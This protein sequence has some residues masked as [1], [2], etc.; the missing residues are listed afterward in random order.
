MIQLRIFISDGVIES[1]QADKES[2][3][4]ISDLLNLQIINFDSDTGDKDVFRRMICDPQMEEIHEY[5]IDHADSED[6]PFAF[7]YQLLDRLKTDCLYFL[8]YGNRN[9][10]YLWGKTVEDHIQEMRR[11]WNLLPLKPEWL[12]MKQ[13][14]EFEQQMKGDKSESET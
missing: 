4:H 5:V 1:V 11:I 9:P 6:G 3:A 7:Q 10:K 8:G 12:T 2:A 14:D 13:I